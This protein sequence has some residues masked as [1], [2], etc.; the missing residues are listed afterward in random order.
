[1]EYM[2]DSPLQPEGVFFLFGGITIIGFIFVW[3]FIKDT[4]GLNDK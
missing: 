2:I 1:M 4:T 3:A